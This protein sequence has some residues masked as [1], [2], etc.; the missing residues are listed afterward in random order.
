MRVLCVEGA[1]VRVQGSEGGPPF[2]TARCGEQCGLLGPEL[3]LRVARFQTRQ[4]ELPVGV[5]RCKRLRLHQ[6]RV[7][8]WHD[9][10]REQG[11]VL[12]MGA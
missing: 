8:A 7:E 1:L 4:D 11:T 2:V 9:K 3:L 10:G 12:L 5:L 6:V